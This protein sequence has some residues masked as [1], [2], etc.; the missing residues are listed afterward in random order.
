MIV[1]WLML[2][3]LVVISIAT[4]LYKLRS[5]TTDNSTDKNCDIC[6]CDDIDGFD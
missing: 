4:E 6:D 2:M 5:I 3:A 1:V